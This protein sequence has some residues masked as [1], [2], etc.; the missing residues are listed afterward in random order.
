VNIFVTGA[1][2]FIGGSLARRLLA[3]GHEVVA[4]YRSD[5]SVRAVRAAGQVAALG[6]LADSAAS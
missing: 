2:G 3:L 6:D 5:D 4:L 1:T